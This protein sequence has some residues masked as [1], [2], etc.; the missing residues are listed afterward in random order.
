MSNRKL[1]RLSLE[2]I[3][4][5]NFNNNCS[6]N[7]SVSRAVDALV[8]GKLS[9]AQK[10][11]Q[12]VQTISSHKGDSLLDVTKQFNLQP[13]QIR[14]LYRHV[15]YLFN[16]TYLQ[17]KAQI[18]DCFLQAVMEKDCLLLYPSMVRTCIYDGD[19]NNLQKLWSEEL[20]K[21][22]LAYNHQFT[23]S[24]PFHYLGMSA[25]SAADNPQMLQMMLD[26][27]TLKDIFYEFNNKEEIFIGVEHYIDKA[28]SYYD[29]YSAAGAQDLESV[30]EVIL[31]NCEHLSNHQIFKV[32]WCVFATALFSQ[33]KKVYTS[34]YQRIVNRWPQEVKVQSL[35][36]LFS[37]VMFD[38]ELFDFFHENFSLSK[39]AKKKLLPNLKTKWA[40]PNNL[41]KLEQKFSLKLDYHK[42][43]LSRSPSYRQDDI[44]PLFNPKLVGLDI[45]RL[46]NSITKAHGL[47]AKEVVSYLKKYQLVVDEKDRLEFSIQAPSANAQK[48][49]K[50]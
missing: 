10:I 19:W 40:H 24:K 39:S 32:Y 45:D 16:I 46:I 26:V 44:L 47:R 17:Q 15:G 48:K 21:R 9:D 33:H 18:R 14:S 50:I 34:V 29:A 27:K 36:N 13:P 12:V 23:V 35:H 2:K 28:Y 43:L 49:Y 25:M 3:K 41:F 1:K 7:V 20:V 8:F 37:F 31:K 22:V 30:M 5:F 4:I 42:V 11:M 38:E 6:P